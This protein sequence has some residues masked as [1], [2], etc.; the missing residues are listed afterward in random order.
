M[1]F[2]VYAMWVCLYRLHDT[3][4]CRVVYVAYDNLRS[5]RDIYWGMGAGG[6]LCC[7]WC[8]SEGWSYVTVGL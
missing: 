8:M 1:C 3:C 5:A 2:I 6:G 7:L 4:I